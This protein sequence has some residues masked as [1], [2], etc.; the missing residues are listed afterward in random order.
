MRHFEYVKPTTIEE[1]TR[2]LGDHADDTL[3]MAGGT[4]AVVLLRLGV[5]RPRYVLDIGGIADL[6]ERTANG[7][8]RLGALTSIRTL[9]RDAEIAR[10]YDVLADA[11]SQVANVRVRNVAT[12]GGTVAYGE[13]QTDTPVALTALGASVEIAGRAGRRSV[14]IVDFYK[15]PYETALE[16]G[17]LVVAVEV[18]RPA[19]GSVGCH[20][21]FTVGSPENKPVANVSATLRIDVSTGTCADATLVLGAVGATPVVAEAAMGLI[22]E[23]V[24][25]D[26][27][28]S[29]A[30]LAAEETDPVEDMRG[31]VW[32]K[33]RIARVLAERALTCALRKTQA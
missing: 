15:G 29:V 4:A 24:D 8:L 10:D 30:A 22:G 27:I 25:E 13:P 5:L 7:T 31:P 16:P 11:A 19:T 9:E 2:F 20:L 23:T 28:K 17:E 26:L 3:V 21:K 12:V 33:R 32:Y 6:R 14:P 18:P 1:A